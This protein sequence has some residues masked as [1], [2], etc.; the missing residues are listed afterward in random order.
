VKLKN[1]KPMP[2]DVLF[3]AYPMIPLSCRSN[4][5]GQYFR[6][7]QKSL[8]FFRY[9]PFSVAS[10]SEWNLGQCRISLETSFTFCWQ[11]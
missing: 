6:R 11:F 7:Q 8:A 10:C 4:L 5:A 2:V 1:K 9:S 3:K